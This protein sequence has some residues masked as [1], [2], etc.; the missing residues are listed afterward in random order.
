M[1]TTYLNTLL[2]SYNIK[3]CDL[4]DV[5]N[6]KTP[7]ISKI[8]N[9]KANMSAEQFKKIGRFLEDKGATIEEMEQLISLYMSETTGF[10][11]E[12]IIKANIELDAFEQL[13]IQKC[14]KLSNDDKIKVFD[15][16]DELLNK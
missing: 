7:Q 11:V 16:I 6:L 2:R 10:N 5:L 9:N 3:G 14:K 1:F 12:K 15:L 13:L 8:R 4:V